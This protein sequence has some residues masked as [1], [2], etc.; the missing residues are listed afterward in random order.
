MI[1]ANK[2]EIVTLYKNKKLIAY[3]PTFRD[4]DS[5]Y[6]KKLFDA[7][8][9]NE[10]YAL[11][12]SLHPATKGAEEYAFNGKFSTYEEKRAEADKLLA[13]L[14]ATGQE[15]QTLLDEAEAR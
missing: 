1:N 5:V 6:I 10:E 3:F 14:V 7:F 2:N 9:D 11:I 13:A 12:V 8:K 4:G 15:Y